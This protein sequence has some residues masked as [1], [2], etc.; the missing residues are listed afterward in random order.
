MRATYLAI[1]LFAAAGC[2]KAAPELAKKV[3]PL[4]SLTPDVTDNP[5]PLELADEAI[6]DA[7]A[8]VK[9]G[10]FEPLTFDPTYWKGDEFGGRPLKVEPAKPFCMVDQKTVAVA[11]RLTVANPSPK[12]VERAARGVWL[13]YKGQVASKWGYGSHKLLSVTVNVYRPMSRPDGKPDLIAFNPPTDK[14]PSVPLLK[15]NE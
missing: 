1:A 10:D 11:V 3:D 6:V 14:L 12:E 2:G 8:K 9:R 7:K 5:N 13:H 4:R 15:W